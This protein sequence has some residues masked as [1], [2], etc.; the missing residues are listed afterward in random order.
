MT[1]VYF[2]IILC[3]GLPSSIQSKNAISVW[4]KSVFPVELG[5]T[6]TWQLTP[7]GGAVYNV[8][9]MIS[10]EI[11]GLR[12]FRIQKSQ[13]AGPYEKHFACKHNPGNDIALSFT[14]TEEFYGKELVLKYFENLDS[15]WAGN[16]PILMRE[17]IQLTKQPTFVEVNMELIKPLRYHE[18]VPTELRLEPPVF[19]TGS[20]VNVDCVTDGSLPPV[21]IMFSIECP[22]PPTAV[23]EHD[24]VTQAKQGMPYEKYYDR[25]GFRSPPTLSDLAPY[26]ARKFANYLIVNGHV[27]RGKD[28]KTI[29]ATLS[30]TEKAHDCHIVCRVAGKETRRRIT[31]YYPTTISYLLP[32]PRDGYM[33][34]GS[35]ITCYADGHPPPMLS[36][37]LAPPLRR[38]N[39][40]TKE[41]YETM[42]ETGRLPKLREQDPVTR[43]LELINSGVD[44]IPQPQNP[45]VDVN[46]N[47]DLPVASSA[48]LQQTPREKHNS[49]LIGGDGKEPYESAKRI[50]GIGLSAMDRHQQLG[51]HP[52][53]YSIQG[54]T[55]RLAPNATPGV[56]L[57]LTCTARNVLPGDTTFLGLTGTMTR[58]RFIVV[59]LLRTNC[60]EPFAATL[61]EPSRSVSEKMDVNRTDGVSSLVPIV[62]M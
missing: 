38:P 59:A 33:Q 47:G 1:L 15:L 10:V 37:R 32:R 52:N 55:F 35:E 43:E 9:S 58:A 12:A 11:D 45:P 6:V 50:P 8:E 49:W 57:L 17:S 25:Y 13:C 36:L 40:L 42:Q 48:T 23:V 39:V 46:K 21:P 61:T 18:H 34:V 27:A 20:N 7:V 31:V 54:A 28:N 24:R 26:V 60:A 14:P 44:L 41:E 56:E 5:E 53:E 19:I 4:P 22:P 2:S 30:I 16:G 62:M 51:L 29:R 3:V